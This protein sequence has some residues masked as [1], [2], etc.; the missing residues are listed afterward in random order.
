MIYAGSSLSPSVFLEDL[1]AEWAED[2]VELEFV[3]VPFHHPQFIMFSS[4]TTG[5]PK[6]MVHSAG[7]SI[8]DTILYSY[9]VHPRI[10]VLI[11]FQTLFNLK[12]YDTRIGTTV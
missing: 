9:T 11:I 10:Y 4:G 2:D 6:C 5:I 1:T 12:L 8:S 7:V 3:Q